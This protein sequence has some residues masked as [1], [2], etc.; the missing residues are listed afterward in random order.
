MNNPVPKAVAGR[1]PLYLRRLEH[2]AAEA[3]ETISSRA[4]AKDLGLGDAQVRKDLAYFGTFGRPGVGYPVRPLIARLR[5]ILGT[6]HMWRLALVGF[7]N[8]GR[9]LVEYKGFQKKA[10]RIEAVFDADPSKVGRRVGDLVVQD[11]TELVETVR[12]LA[13]PMAIVTVPAEE[14]RAVADRLVDAGVMGILNFAPVKLD[15]PEDVVVNDVDLAMALEQ[16]SFLASRRH[17]TAPAAD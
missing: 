17:R 9:A 11:G 2:L 13:I 5:K 6:D 16:L 1:L 10:F 7:G 8:L 15:V 4:L 14:A 3:V 12:R